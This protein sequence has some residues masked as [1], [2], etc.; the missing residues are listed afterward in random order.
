MNRA[1]EI[2]LCCPDCKA[3]LRTEK[4][5][6]HC[7]RCRR[8]F[9]IV[10]GIPS[11]TEADASYEGRWA[12]THTCSGSAIRRVK[13]WFTPGR[14][15]A[16]KYMKRKGNI[17]DLGCGG[18][19]AFYSNIGP[20]AGVDI[21]M[22]SVVRAGKIYD[23]V[24]RANVLK[25]P[26]ADESFDYVI[27]WDLFGHIA[28]E[29]KDGLIEEIHRVLKKNGQTIHYIETRGNDPLERFA[30]RYPD[31]Y[32]K[33]FIRKDGHFGLETPDE[34][35][36]RFKKNGFRLVAKRPQAFTGLRFPK[37]YLKRFD[38]EYKRES[39]VIRMLVVFCGFVKKAIP[40]EYLMEVFVVLCEKIYAGS[41][42]FNNASGIYVC[43]KKAKASIC[44]ISGTYPPVR[45]GIGDYT[46]KLIG[47]LKKDGLKMSLVTSKGGGI[48][49]HVNETDYPD[50]LPDIK[51]WNIYA[52]RAILGLI[53][54]NEFDIVHIQY[55]TLAYRR[56]LSLHFLPLFIR[57]LFK[58]TKAVTTLHEFSIGYPFNKIRQFF[59]ALFS[60]RLVVT[61]KKDYDQ[62]L[63][64][65]PG[66]ERKM[67][68]I[69][70]GSNIDVCDYNPA[71]RAA[72]IKNCGLG[73]DVKII[74]FFG[75]IHANKGFECLLRAVS[76]ALHDDVPVC[77]NVISNFDPGRIPYHA[78]IKRLI[79]F[80]GIEKSVHL[81]GYASPEKVS[82]LLSLSD[83]CVLPFTDGATLRRGTLIAAAAHRKPIIST[84]SKDYI[85]PQL[86]D[87][88]NI[89]LVPINDEHKLKEAIKL[90]CADSA[91]RE[92][93]GAGAG[94]LAKEF[95][96]DKIAEAHRALYLDMT[97]GDCGA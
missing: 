71:E 46:F 33:Y 64:I 22:A 65:L 95:S 70:V 3:V 66:A 27:S 32:D 91:L 56:T 4:N 7:E 52:V 59:L 75:V 45:D 73:D 76:G 9:P 60:H 97:G 83:L 86:I 24:A 20:V 50:V 81:T 49:R 68:V 30:L 48:D 42:P 29:D 11:F 25:L 39:F 62:I 85:P 26:F 79:D 53:E 77:L 28:A 93:L 80:L 31:L 89:L 21:S 38:N 5:A 54:K 82:R 72:F 90:L 67:R 40:L 2:N 18:G 74:S 78:G 36:R 87:K 47:R 37:E 88:E 84:R 43:F 13:S 17:L 10:K 69:P 44:V 92:R 58:H 57:A 8:S 61:E 34:T 12:E 94:L 16:A 1:D 51:R 19:N 41:F 15:F 63:R 23:V 96:W 35:V 55:P 6:L 14:M